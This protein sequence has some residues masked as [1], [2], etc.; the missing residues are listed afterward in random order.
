[1]E[2]PPLFFPPIVL[3]VWED[4]LSVKEAAGELLVNCVYSELCVKETEHSRG[5]VDVLRAFHQYYYY[6]IIS[7]YWFVKVVWIITIIILYRLWSLTPSL[8]RI[9]FKATYDWTP[10]ICIKHMVVVLFCYIHY[11]YTWSIL[12]KCH[13]YK[14]VYANVVIRWVNCIHTYIDSSVS[15]KQLHEQKWA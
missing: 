1:M 9:Y 3:L 15:R 5:S 12:F 14:L 13:G 7:Y 11:F 10:L 8:I 6:I 4:S 2:K